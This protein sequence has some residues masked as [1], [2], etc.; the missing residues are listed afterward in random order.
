MKTYIK[1]LIILS[2]S[3]IIFS[4]NDDNEIEKEDVRPKIETFTMLYDGSEINNPRAGE[5]YTGEVLNFE[6][7]M[8]DKW[9]LTR[10]WIYEHRGNDSTLYREVKLYDKVETVEVDYFVT[11][12]HNEDVRVRFLVQN[13]VPDRRYVDYRVVVKERPYANKHTAVI[14]H[15]DDANHSSTFSAW[16]LL[17]ATGYELIVGNSASVAKADAVNDNASGD[18]VETFHAKNNTRYCK[19]A[20]GF[21]YENASLATSRD[22]YNNGTNCGDRPSI[23]D[24][25]VDAIF[26]ARLRGMGSYIPIKI[27][28]VKTEGNGSIAFEFKN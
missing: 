6:I 23:N 5:H 10:L 26:I 3:L 12:E 27:T 17:E 24:M 19:A 20:P 9:G 4:C 21:D 25:A 13:I 8:A 2:A 18:L 16:N 7:T 14:V 1:G 15:P 22:A 11:G 28:E